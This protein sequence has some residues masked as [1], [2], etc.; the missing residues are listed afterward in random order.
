MDACQWDGQAKLLIPL[1]EYMLYATNFSGPCKGSSNL[2]FQIQGN[3]K[4]P[5][6][7]KLFCNKSFWISFQNVN[8]LEIEGDGILDG[9]GAYAWNNS[10]CNIRPSTLALDFI[11]NA[12][13]R[14]IHSI[15]SK[16]FQIDVFRSNNLTFSRVN[17]TAPDDSPNTD[18]I[19]I[20]FST[21]INIFDSV[22]GTGDDCISMIAGSQNINISG[23]TCGPGHGISIG[24]LG[25]LPN[26]EVV[27][28]IR[29][30]NC[31][32]TATQNGVRIKT[33]APSDSGSA[34]TI[35]FEDIIM[36]DVRNPIFIDQHYCTSRPC[37]AINE[38][39]SVQIKDVTFNNIQGTSISIVAIT[40]NCS[41]T[42]PC[43]EIKFNDINLVYNGLDG[44]AISSCDNAEGTATGKEVPPSCLKSTSDSSA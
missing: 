43:K 32:L 36:N 3:I 44:H 37:E 40:L 25:K 39:S 15:N 7:P 31:T 5:I 26:E 6:D 42:Y 19:H 18:G 4:A 10:Q 22:I 1:G 11:E 27:K 21:N 9:Q 24:S 16:G 34:T 2:N 20:G 35:S 13:V 38:E 29:V 14:D 8:N 33:R 12:I 28:D 23:V 30:R 41:A 17:I